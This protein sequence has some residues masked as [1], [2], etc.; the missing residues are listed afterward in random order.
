MVYRFTIISN[1]VDDF[2]REIRIDAG[3]TFYDLHQAILAACHY[4]DDQPTSFFTCN[5]NW[6]Q[7]QEV[8]LEDMGTSREDEDVYLM[9][10]TRLEDLLED[11]KQRLVYVFDPLGNRMLFMELTE[12]ILGKAEPQPVCSRSK[13]EAPQQTIDV[14][15]LLKRDATSTSENLN[16]DFSD[17]ENFDTDEFDPEGFEIS[18]GD[19]FK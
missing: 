14:E 18:D 15:E 19:P 12:I 6:E 13:G 9:K 7:E 4:T 3:A 17:N 2:L 11:E 5:R 16:D 1:E 8:L 10:D